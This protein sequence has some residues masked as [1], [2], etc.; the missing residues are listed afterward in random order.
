QLTPGR[1]DAIVSGHTH[2]RVNTVVNGVTI[3]QAYSRGTAIEIVD[4]PVG[5]RDGAATPRAQ[6]RDVNTDS[7]VPDAAVQRIVAAALTRVAPIVTRPVATIRDAMDRDSAAL[8]NLIADA[9]R[10]Q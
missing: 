4:L 2:S 6:I 5:A 8:G 1:V 3:V 10:S 9:F 7:L